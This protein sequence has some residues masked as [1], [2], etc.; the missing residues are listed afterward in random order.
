MAERE[1]IARAALYTLAGGLAG[2]AV[3]LLFA[4]QSGQR[5]REDI[6]KMGQNVAGRVK[7]FQDDLTQRVETFVDDYKQMA[8]AGVLGGR[9]VRADVYRA[10]EAS[11][12]VLND[13]IQQLENLVGRPS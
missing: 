7:H 8:K 12:Q 2:A 1:V 10:L 5:T 13:K 4:P 9:D 11:R 3:A 6:R